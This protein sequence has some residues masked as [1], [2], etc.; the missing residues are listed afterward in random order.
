MIYTPNEVVVLFRGNQQLAKSGICGAGRGATGQRGKE[1]SI[2]GTLSYLSNPVVSQS[3]L[4]DI[5]LPVSSTKLGPPHLHRT[6]TVISRDTACSRVASSVPRRETGQFC[7]I[8]TMDCPMAGQ[9]GVQ[10]FPSLLCSAWYSRTTNLQHRNSLWS[11]TL[12]QFGAR[13]ECE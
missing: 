3:F 12:E 6:Q 8:D 7:V 5:K 13:A 1:F 2:G 9:Q 11:P 10:A 4:P